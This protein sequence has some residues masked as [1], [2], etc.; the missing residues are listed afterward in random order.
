MFSPNK[1]SFISLK[2]NGR[3]RGGLIYPSDDVI[4]ICFQTEKVLRSFNYK[5]KSVNALFV[6]SKVFSYFL[7]NTNIFSSLNI[8]SKE[9]YSPLS[10]H[11][12]LIIKSISTIYIKIKINHSLKAL[13]E[14]P[15]LRMWYNKITN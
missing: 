7:Y 8:H 1:D 13:N 9:S 6:Q 3:N 11:V 2:N 15:S 5:N 12:T 10:D 14:K 4:T